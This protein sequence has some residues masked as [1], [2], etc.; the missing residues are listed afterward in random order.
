MNV[1]GTEA[2]QNITPR[3]LITRLVVYYGCL[4]A[5]ITA[6]LLAHSDSLQYLPFGGNDAHD[7][8]DFEVTETS[9]RMPRELLETGM[10]TRD[11]TPEMFFLSILFLT[12]TLITTVLVMIPVT[13]TYAATRYEAGPS[14]V[15]VRALVLLPIAATAVVLLIQDSLALAFGLAAL[16]AAVRYRVSLPEAIDGICIFVAICVGL[17]AGVGFMGVALIMTLVFTL[18]NA[19]LWQLDYGRNPLDDARQDVAAA[20]LAAKLRD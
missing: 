9:I 13:W 16:V 5:I 8:K 17:A 7:R 12:G 19:V 3:Q 20:K 4:L 14:K 18:T 10:A 2:K 6:L 1:R 11:V 15:F